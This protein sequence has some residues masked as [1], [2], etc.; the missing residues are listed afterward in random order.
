VADDVQLAPR[1]IGLD[2]LEKFGGTPLD[3]RCRQGG[4]GVNIRLNALLIE[5]AFETF[6]HVVEI[7]DSAHICEP[8]ESRDKEDICLS[9]H[10]FMESSRS[11]WS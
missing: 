5:V 8:E 10:F 3:T 2:G 6:T 11:S 9:H 4:H 1:V 7:G